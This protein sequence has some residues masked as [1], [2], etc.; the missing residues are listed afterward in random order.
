MH[1]MQHAQLIED[2]TRTELHSLADKLNE[3]L[4]RFDH[5]SISD[6]ILKKPLSQL[7][8]WRAEAH[9]KIDQIVE[10]KRREISDELDKYRKGLLT[11]NEEQLVKINVSKKMIA[12][13]IQEGDASTKQMADLQSS[14][15]EAE[16]YLKALNVPVIDIIAQPSD[17]PVN[18]YTNFFDVQATS[19]DKVREF[20]I[21]YVRLNGVIRNYYVTTKDNGKISDLI[22]SFVQHCTAVE[23]FTPVG[24]NR[25]YTIDH[26]PKPDFILAAEV[27]NHRIYLQFND[28]TSLSS[29]EKRDVIVFHE[30]PYS[31]NDQNNPCILMPCSFRRLPDKS[32]FGWPVYLSVP[33]TGCRGQHI[34]G[35]LQDLLGKFF[36]LNPDTD[37]QLYEAYL[38]MIV[39]YTTKETKLNDFLQDEIDFSKVSTRL[40]VNIV[41]HIADEY[42]QNTLK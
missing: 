23:V 7:E 15:N 4:S 38:E 12:E 10:D 31:L 37:Q 39:N 41:S 40:F 29:I 14:I 3:L 18:I 13:L 9:E 20:K 2:K 28:N 27:Y 1:L 42:E 16:K 26:L 22:K 36:P 24:L 35:A 6:D 33:R 11:K 32:L 17:W 21:T 30:T 25:A 8:K 34:L 5:F 19:V